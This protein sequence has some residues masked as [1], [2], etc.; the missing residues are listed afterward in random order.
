MAAPVFKKMRQAKKF[1]E[2]L[3]F[4][5]TFYVI[6][7]YQLGTLFVNTFLEKM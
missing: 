2:N 6:K 7:M 3:N 1:A 5:R 4:P